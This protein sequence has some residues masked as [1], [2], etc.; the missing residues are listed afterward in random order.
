MMVIEPSPREELI[1][2]VLKAASD[3]ISTRDFDIQCQL[4]PATTGKSYYD[5]LRVAEKLIDEGIIEKTDDQLRIVAKVAPSW[6]KEGLL[7]GSAISWE[8]LEAIDIKG[9]IKGKID[10]ELLAAIGF[11]G[12]NEVIRQ[13][14]NVLPCH[15]ASRITHISLKDDSAGFDI[16]SPSTVH[17]DATRLLEVKTSSRPGA[18]FKF[19]ISRNE[20]R[21]A[22]LNENWRLVAVLRHSQDYRIL[23][24]LN[25]AH[26]SSTLP[27]DSSSFS[28]WESASVTVPVDLMAPGLP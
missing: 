8:I 16:A 26:F 1:L 27:T 28:K 18:D 7:T 19:F 9:K 3:R 4:A 11:E 12:E 22:S 14:K 6:L 15:L 21:V 25:Y 17:N 24:H 13:L 2:E 5:R 23:G 20:A 10:V